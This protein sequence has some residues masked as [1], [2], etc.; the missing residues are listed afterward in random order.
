M[1]RMAQSPVGTMSKKSLQVRYLK[2]RVSGNGSCSIR[3]TSSY[4][5]QG[6]ETGALLVSKV[7]IVIGSS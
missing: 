5:A 6:T 3:E 1:N 2:R 4:E 7:V